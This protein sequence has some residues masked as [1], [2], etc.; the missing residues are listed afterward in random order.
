VQVIHTYWRKI[1]K[2]IKNKVKIA[3]GVGDASPVVEYS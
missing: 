1:H 3:L 2:I